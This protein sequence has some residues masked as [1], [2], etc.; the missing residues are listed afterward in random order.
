MDVK[1]RELRRAIGDAATASIEQPILLEHMS[2]TRDFIAR[3]RIC[4]PSETNESE[5]QLADMEDQ[6]SGIQAKIDAG[7]VA[8][9]E[10]AHVDKFNKTYR[11]AVIVPRLKHLELTAGGLYQGVMILKEKIDR[12]Q[13]YQDYEMYDDYDFD[14]LEE[15]KSLCKDAIAE[16][17]QEMAQI[18]RQIQI[19]QNIR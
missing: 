15:K 17:S 19:L 16:Y 6:A 13:Y 2:N 8:E 9:T 4:D 12:Y 11:E 5:A 7:R 1:A 18:A 14:E 10:M 3:N